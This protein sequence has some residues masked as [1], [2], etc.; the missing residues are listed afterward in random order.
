MFL[1]NLETLYLFHISQFEFMV[2][3][4]LQSLKQSLQSGRHRSLKSLQLE[5]NHDLQALGFCLLLPC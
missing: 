1:T 4:A 5:R 3:I 2:A